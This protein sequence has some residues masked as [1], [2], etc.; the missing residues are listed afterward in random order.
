MA[1]VRGPLSSVTAAI[2][3]HK[4]RSQGTLFI[5]EEPIVRTMNP[6]AQSKVS[7]KISKRSIIKDR[8]NN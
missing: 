3:N 7:L 4:K 5:K 8:E 1:V 6:K 2:V